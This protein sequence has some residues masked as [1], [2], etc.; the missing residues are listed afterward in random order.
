MSTPRRVLD[1]SSLPTVVFGRK[2][3]VA[4]GTIGFMVIE[5]FTTALMAASYLYLRKN[6]IDWPPGRT[7]DPDLLAGT[8]NTVVLLLAILPLRAASAAAHRF[9]RRG[10]ARWL[11]VG[12]TMSLIAVILRW[13]ELV[14][15]NARWDAH[16][17]GSAAWGLL[18]V[19]GTLLLTDLFETGTMAILFAKGPVERRL[20][21]DASDAAAYQYFLSLSQIPVYL[22]V[23]W[24]PRIL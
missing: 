8:L 24:A 4:W 21:P 12:A 7:L 5:G 19:H 11:T 16:A 17:Y 20:F 10:V 1:V 18:V 2:D 15:L 22:I 3:V 13:Y 23:F 14:A 6:E 9:D